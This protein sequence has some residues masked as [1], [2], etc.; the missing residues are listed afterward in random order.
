MR[1]DNEQRNK[2]GKIT[3]S[4]EVNIGMWMKVM[5]IQ[6]KYVFALHES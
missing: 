4:I 2:K 5:Q 6:T 3:N 1:G